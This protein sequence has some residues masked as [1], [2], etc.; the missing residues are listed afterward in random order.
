MLLTA[1]ILGLFVSV[2]LTLSL[3]V[4]ALLEVAFS[5]SRRVPPPVAE[6]RPDA[7]LPLRSKN[8][9][10]VPASQPERCLETH[11]SRA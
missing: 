3:G 10:T 2:A 5:T 4:L 6:S 11:G 9:S 1:V 7:G 8:C